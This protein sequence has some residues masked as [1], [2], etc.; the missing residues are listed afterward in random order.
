[1]NSRTAAAALLALAMTTATAAPALRCA[2]E[3]PAPAAAGG[4]VPLRFSLTNA[5]AVPLWVLRWNTPFEGAWYS[6]YVEVTR[7][8]HA[9]PYQ[10]AMKKRAEPRGEQYV[11]LEPGATRTAQVDLA[12][13]FELSKP[14]RY[15]VVPRLHLADVFEATQAEPPLPRSGFHDLALACAA[16]DVTIVAR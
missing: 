10:G 11:R 16:F 2:F 5:G 8:G 9:L 7:D 1:M 3:A 4:P 6:A 12:N 13:A 15:R 14:G